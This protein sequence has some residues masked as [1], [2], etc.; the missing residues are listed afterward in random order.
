MLLLK[1]CVHSPGKVFL[2]VAV[3]KLMSRTWGSRL[4]VVVSKAFYCNKWK[5]V[6]LH[7]CV[8][9]WGQSVLCWVAYHLRLSPSQLQPRIL[10]L[11]T[12]MASEDVISS[13]TPGVH[14]QTRQRA[15]LDASA[16]SLLTQVALPSSE[17]S[18]LQSSPKLCTDYT[19]HLFLCSFACSVKKNKKSWE[20]SKS[21]FS[22][23]H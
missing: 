22:M 17:H 23:T 14:W 10:D 18:I 2:Q 21:Y 5:K 7:K 9:P 8:L 11:R 12:Q 15:C 1:A 20:S 3:S 13:S 16:N 6:C 4:L 19:T